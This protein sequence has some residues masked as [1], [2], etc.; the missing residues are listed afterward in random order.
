MKGRQILSRE[1]LGAVGLL[2]R[3]K[4]T[5]TGQV[6]DAKGSHH[7]IPAAM[8]QWRLRETLSPARVTQQDSRVPRMQWV[9]CG[10]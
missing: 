1:G 8:G 7:S 10:G 3:P 2:Q 5:A 4:R 9:L 6:S